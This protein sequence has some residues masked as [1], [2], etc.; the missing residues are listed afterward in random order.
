MFSSLWSYSINPYIPLFFQFFF[1][2]SV[3][4]GPSSYKSFAKFL[5]GLTL[6]MKRYYWWM[7]S[8]SKFQPTFPNNLIFFALLLILQSIVQFSNYQIKTSLKL[9]RKYYE[10]SS[11]K[12]PLCLP[13]SM[14]FCP[15]KNITHWLW[16]TS[17]W[18]L[19]NSNGTPW[20]ETHSK[21]THF[22]LKSVIKQYCIIYK[23]L[24]DFCFSRNT[25]TANN[26]SST[27]NTMIMCMILKTILL[28]PKYTWEEIP[29]LL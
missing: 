21:G 19:Y 5:V 4:I 24:L 14:L 27:V 15:N 13:R 9:D 6:S 23:T 26:N 17:C 8:F 18:L 20:M 25:T 1:I 11:P 7:C 16:T 29:I 2:K 22:I 12:V 28:Q 10:M 3:W